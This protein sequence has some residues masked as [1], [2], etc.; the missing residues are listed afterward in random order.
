MSKQR[1]GHQISFNKAARQAF[2]EFA[3]SPDARWRGNFRDLNAAVQRMSTL[4]DGGRINEINV[5]EEIERLRHH[6]QPSTHSPT[7]SQI[8]LS[9]YL[10]TTALDD[11]DQFDKWQLQKVIQ[12]CRDSR[13]LSDAGRILFDRSRLKKNST[14]DSHRLRQY[15]S[16]FGLSYE[17]IIN[18]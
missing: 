11:I 8:Q 16:K 18:L 13:S 7:E 5:A 17:Q 10:S 4:A 15:L 12:V 9:D 14:N 6:W 3:L 1:K 2:L